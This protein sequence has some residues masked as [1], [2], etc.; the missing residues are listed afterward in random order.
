MR[1]LVDEPTLVNT[2]SNAM[3]SVDRLMFFDGLSEN[4]CSFRQATVTTVR[5]NIMKN[6]TL[7][8]VI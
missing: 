4:V 5:D 7:R 8:I 2:V 3:V 6:N 1:I